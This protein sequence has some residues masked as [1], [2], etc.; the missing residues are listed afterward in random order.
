MKRIRHIAIVFVLILPASV[1]A[2]DQFFDS[3][4]VKI[5]YVVE[6]EGE[7][8][9]LIHGFT[10]SVERPWKISG[11]FQD[12]TKD[13]QVIALD[14]R[15]HGKSG[16][17]HEPSAYGPAMSRDVANL[18]D[19]LEIDKAHIAGYSMGAIITLHFL[20]NYPEKCLSAVVGGHG[21]TDPSNER[22]AS[23]NSVAE[24]LENGE[25]LRPLIELLTPEGEPPPSDERV[26]QISAMILATND[27]LALAAVSRGIPNLYVS[28]D[29]LKGNVVPTLGIVGEND[30]LR[31]KTEAMAE[32]MPHTDIV[33]V[34]GANHATA[35]TNPMFVESMRKFLEAQSGSVQSDRI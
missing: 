32:N 27:P 4:G 21:W 13:Y 22:P 28:K 16:K 17:P 34:T 33:V 8:F 24:A 30:P 25:G 23:S 29:Q 1:L 5:R 3:D 20:I 9:V 26:E 12:L 18:L 14:C 19:H 2:E 15:G 31:A 11:V 35:I 10:G 7:P 6:G